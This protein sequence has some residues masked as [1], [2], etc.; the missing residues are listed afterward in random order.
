M[1]LLA[2]K[3]PTE[4]NKI[5]AAGILGLVALVSLYLAFGRGMMGGSSASARPT[6]SPTPSR[7]G[8]APRGDTAMPSIEEQQSVYESTPVVYRPDGFRAP[9]P[10][11]NI[12]AFY[13]PPPPCP[14]SE[15]PPP[16]PKPV[17]PKPATPMPTPWMRLTMVNPAMVYAGSRGFRLEVLGDQFTPDARIYFNQIQMPTTYISPQRLAADIPANLIAGEGP[18]QV[19]VQTPD[20]QKYSDQTMLT[21]QAPPKPSFQYV[22]MIARARGNNDTAIFERP[23]KPGNFSHR[24]ND[25]IDQRFRLI[26]ISREETVFE[27]VQLGFKH[28]VPVTRTTPPPGPAGPN[29]F[30]QIDPSTMQNI[31]GIPTNIPRYNPQG[32]QPPPPGSVMAVPQVKGEEKKEVDDA[33]IDP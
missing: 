6:P 16:T 24:L 5:I 7:A 8:T 28:R 1:A 10:G 33:A 15:C 25:V 20:G 14:P 29:P 17:E 23:G 11:R 3:T 9:D 19:I 27:D 21:V 4:R 12:F 30:P 31:P 13:E 2:G 32:G 22:G 26:S 18:R